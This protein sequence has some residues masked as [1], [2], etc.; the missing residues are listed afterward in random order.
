M[1]VLSGPELTSTDLRFAQ[2]QPASLELRFGD[3]DW[4]GPD[5]YF[6]IT[7]S[8]TLPV[9]GFAASFSLQYDNHV[10]RG[11]GCFVSAAHQPGAA[12]SAET[13]CP[14]QVRP[15][16]EQQAG[17]TA[18]QGAALLVDRSANWRPLLPVRSVL[19][20]VRS[21]FCLPA[22]ASIN[23][24]FDQLSARNRPDVSAR[25]ER[26]ASQGSLSADRW[27]VLSPIVRPVL[28]SDWGTA[29]AQHLVADVGFAKAV[30]RHRWS[31]LVWQEANSPLP[32]VS[33]HSTTPVIPPDLYKP[34]TALRFTEKQPA[35]LA[36]LFRK[37]TETEAT[38]VVPVRTLYMTINTQSLK[39]AETGR[40]IEA[41][42]IRLSI[43]ADSWTWS[44]SADV[45]GSEWSLLKAPV[46]ELLD[47]LITLNGF[48]VRGTIERRGRNRS[49]ANTGVGISGRGR[50]AWLSDPHSDK[51]S[52]SN[53]EMMTAQ[54][55]MA[56]ALTD[57]GVSMG[58]DIDWQLTDWAVPAGAWS[59]TGTPIEACLAV[60]S[61]AGGYIQ[62]DPISEVFHVL[63]RYPVAPWAWDSVTP[64]YDLPEDVCTFEGIEEIDK[65]RHNSV[66]VV[67]QA[68]GVL[69][70]V[71]RQ[72]SD[73]GSPAPMV[74]NSLI[75]H[76]DAGGQA[77][78]AALA[79]T[80]RQEIITVSLPVLAETGVILPGK[81]IRYR[82][83][84][85]ARIGLSRGVSLS[86][87]F[88]KV[89]QSI[90]VETHVS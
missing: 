79:N 31:D 40:E 6:D 86:G 68:N 54:Q 7:F 29:A 10:S 45:P 11:P 87:D 85:N 70:N 42:N 38:I 53:A 1:S 13:H 66:V 8:A 62:A 60:A 19:P 24:G 49:F 89:S 17:I 21:E 32:G 2:L 78:L 51:S 46:G 18:A 59:H 74:V 30:A 56:A 61:A 12:V 83:N 16:L 84:G 43:D 44:W 37:K 35:S 33:D 34:D 5:E 3:A 9:T 64:D 69:C 41:K 88:P 26:A 55:I 23:D 28:R 63:P 47:V 57:N 90:R 48:A 25:A 76:P 52:R 73:G 81:F 75:T 20:V 67:G 71:T 22:G 72:G 27:V 77:G 50:A 58:W 65:P 36:L 14:N 82:E 39:V 15:V 4:S 80:G